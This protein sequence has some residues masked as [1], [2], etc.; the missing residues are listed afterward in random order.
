MEAL[1]WQ[2]LESYN[3]GATASMIVL[4][5][6]TLWVANVGKLQVVIGRRNAK[7][8][9]IDANLVSAVHTPESEPE[10]QRI[11]KAGGIVGKWKLTNVE[12]VGETCV[13]KVD[14]KTGDANK[15]SQIGINVSRSLGDFRAKDIGIIADPTIN[16]I[17]LSKDDEFI[18]V[19]SEGL[20]GAIKAQEA[21][22][23]VSQYRDSQKAAEA[24]T[25]KAED[26][27][28]MQFRGENVSACVI[29]L[30]NHLVDTKETLTD[31]TLA[32]LA[33]L[34]GSPKSP[35]IRELQGSKKTTRSMSVVNA[36]EYVK[37]S[38]GFK[39]SQSPKTSPRDIS[40]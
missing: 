39:N 37:E 40:T 7:T 2:G 32:A 31:A 10:K 18:I 11:E 16:Q 29:S 22:D 35:L 24:L 28:E 1:L 30:A 36:L 19:G 12:N 25:L 27:W 33:S 4:T 13:W 20:W 8:G 34:E 38:L 14:S 21:V 17:S 26:L 3:S 9:K 6:K 23:L 15:S 5:G